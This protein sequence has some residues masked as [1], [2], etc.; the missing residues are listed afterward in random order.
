M[1]SRGPARRVLASALAGVMV[2]VALG[3]G[4]N[5]SPPEPPPPPPE[6]VKFPEPS[7]R[8]FRDL[9]GNYPG[10]PVVAP[11]VSILEPGENRFGFALFDRGNRQIGDLEVALYLRVWE[12]V[13][14]GSGAELLD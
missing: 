5:E 1:R 13:H 8:S 4:E 6:P 7:G 10:G 3:C 12:A 2:A 9:I 14:P 11:S